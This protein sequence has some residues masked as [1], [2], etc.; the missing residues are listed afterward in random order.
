[1]SRWNFVV[2]CNLNYKSSGFNNWLKIDYKFQVKLTSDLKLGTKFKR[3]W[4]WF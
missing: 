4:K 1:M 3:I 2:I